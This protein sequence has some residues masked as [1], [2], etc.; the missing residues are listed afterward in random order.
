MP[1]RNLLPVLLLPFA[2]VLGFLLRPA[3][4]AWV[5]PAH[6]SVT[7]VAERMVHTPDMATASALPPEGLYVAGSAFGLV[8]VRCTDA[9]PP[10]GAT[11]RVS[12]TLDTVCGP[13]SVPCYPRVTGECENA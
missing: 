10:P 8:Y 3:L 7:G 4:T 2:F 11:L 9:E 6:V 13:D 12:G 1:V 5:F